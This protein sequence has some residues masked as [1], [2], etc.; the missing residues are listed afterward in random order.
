MPASCQGI[1]LPC[2]YSQDIQFIAK[3]LSIFSTVLK[4]LA[5]ALEKGPRY[6]P[7]QPDVY[8]I[9]LRVVRECD[10]IFREIERIIKKST[11]KGASLTGTSHTLQDENTLTLNFLGKVMWVYRRARVQ[12]L[13]SNLESL[14]STIMLELVLL[15]HADRNR[16]H[17]YR[18][19]LLPLYYSTAH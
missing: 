3:D 16:P 6:R 13:R 14:K 17:R 10:S 19:S 11:S 5:E 1:L 2:L 8:K 18:Q 7:Y 4:Q 12:F 15:N 9:S